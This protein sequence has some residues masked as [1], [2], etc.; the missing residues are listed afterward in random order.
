MGY[1]KARPEGC[2]I[3]VACDTCAVS[4]AAFIGQIVVRMGTDGDPFD[5]ALLA[6]L[7]PCA[8]KMGGGD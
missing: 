8:C 2:E 4:K 7:K 1:A 5:D 3:R 6:D